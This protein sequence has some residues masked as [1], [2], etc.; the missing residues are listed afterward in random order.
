[1]PVD[2]Y[3]FGKREGVRLC[4]SECCGLPKLVGE[5]SR[6]GEISRQRGLQPNRT[7]AYDSPTGMDSSSEWVARIDLRWRPHRPR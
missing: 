5:R 3:S 1:M 7:Q 6:G 4:R 2:W